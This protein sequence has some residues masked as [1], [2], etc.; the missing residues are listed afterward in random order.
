MIYNSKKGVLLY[1]ADGSGAGA[2][3]QVTTL[4]KNLKM[5]YADFFVV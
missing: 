1:D 4:S 5:T 3:V 2:A